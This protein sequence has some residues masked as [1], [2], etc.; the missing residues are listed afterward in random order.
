LGGFGSFAALGGLGACTT[1]FTGSDSFTDKEDSERVSASIVIICSSIT[2]ESYYQFLTILVKL[3]ETIL[4]NM[5]II[6]NGRYSY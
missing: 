2:I 1:A 4:I 3:I 6:Y 5:F